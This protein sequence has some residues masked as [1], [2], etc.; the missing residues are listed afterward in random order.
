MHSNVKLLLIGT[1][2]MGKEYAKVLNSLE[3]DYDVVGNSEKGCK[4]FSEETGKEAHPGGVDTIKKL[5]PKG[6]T[7]AINA[8]PIESLHDIT[9]TLLS[10]NITKV[11]IE[12]PVALKKS[13]FEYI[14]DQKL[15]S[16]YVAYN[17]RFYSSVDK[18]LEI[19]KEDGGITSLNF[20]FTEWTD[21]IL[22]DFSNKDV[23]EN[24]F[25]CNSS[26]V[27]DLA[28]FI[29]GRPIDMHCL[30]QAP[31]D[32]HSAGTIFAGSG[33][34]DKNVIFTYKANWDS[35]GRWGV[36]A[37][38]KNRKLILCPMEGLK[39]VMRNSVKEEEINLGDNPDNEF[40]PG[41]YNMVKAFLNNETDKLQTTHKFLDEVTDV[42]S[43][44]MG[45]ENIYF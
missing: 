36:E 40:K 27:A 24:W 2:K 10:L 4:S 39:Q 8:V 35:A 38:T 18:L 34:T 30:A 7:A 3:V 43:K 42:Y 28:F 5:A 26:H 44:M 14:K 9:S 22:E 16:L 17:R 20:E 12:K 11:L 31:A 37:H 33:K 13:E 41:L 15:D 1:G 45:K 21:G 25:L 19:A 32:W 6:Y 23:L 29:A